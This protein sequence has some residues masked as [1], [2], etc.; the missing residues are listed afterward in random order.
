MRKV[1][2]VL[3][4]ILCLFAHTQQVSLY[5]TN[6]IGI[7]L[8]GDKTFSPEM[9]LKI[10]RHSFFTSYWVL[11]PEVGC[12]IRYVKNPR[13]YI[14]SSGYL[15]GILAYDPRSGDFL[16]SFVP[17]VHVCG[18]E[19]YPFDRDYVGISIYA[20]SLNFENLLGHCALLVRF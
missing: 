3:F 16:H 15:A 6:K 13:A 12:K 10:E 2:T 9:I 19:V 5:D 8:N 1:F 11:Y 14:Y 20:R 7:G 4:T 18:V 17:D